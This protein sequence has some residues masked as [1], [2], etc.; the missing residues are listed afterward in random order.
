[1]NVAVKDG[2]SYVTLPDTEPAALVRVNDELV[3]VLESIA[4]EKVAVAVVA[5]ETEPEPDAG[6]NDVKVGGAGAA[7][8]TV[9]DQTYAPARC[10]P[11]VV[12]IAVPSRAVYVSDSESAAV[13]WRIATLV[14]E[15]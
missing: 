10:T 11:S 12:A 2:L 4:R 15:L 5:V 1:V 9:N 8:A 13:G 6:V 14:V 7:A 3:S